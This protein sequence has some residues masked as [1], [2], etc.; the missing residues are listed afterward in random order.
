MPATYVCTCRFSIQ[1]S[2]VLA[3]CTRPCSS[4]TSTKL[5]LPIQRRR[6]CTSGAERAKL[7][8][9]LKNRQRGPGMQVLWCWS[10]STARARLQ[11]RATQPNKH[12][13]SSSLAS[14]YDGLHCVAAKVPPPYRAVQVQHKCSFATAV[15]RS[16]RHLRRPCRAR[17]ARG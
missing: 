2:S 11:L 3:I 9:Q 1:R 17:S 14:S 16:R 8:Y 5:L 15:G 10:H 7:S 13:S 4:P 6:A 12:A